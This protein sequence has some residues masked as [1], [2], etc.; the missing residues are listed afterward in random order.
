MPSFINSAY[1]QI[2]SLWIRTILFITH[3]IFQRL[4]PDPYTKAGNVRVDTKPAHASRITMTEIISPDQCDLKG[5]AYAGTI[6]SWIDIAAGIA[7]KRHA[8][9]PSV[10]RSVDDVAFLHP[11]KV[12]D[13]VSIQAS[14]NKSWKTSMEVGVKVEAESP[15]TNERFFVAHAYLTFVALSPRPTAKTHVGRVLSEYQPIRVPELIPTSSMEINRFEMAEKRRQARF[16][17]KKVDYQEIRNRMRE[18]SQ[19]LRTMADEIAP[20]KEHPSYSVVEHASPDMQNTQEEGSEEEDTIVVHKLERRFSQDPRMVQQ[21]K[22]KLM[23]ATFAE[24]VELVMPQHANTLSITFGGQI[25]AWMELCARVSANRLAKAYLLT[26]SIDSLNFIASSGVGDVVTI[27]SVVSRSFNSSMEV[28][29]SVEAENLS[30]GETKFTNDGFFTITAVDQENVPVV[31]PRIIPQT[32]A[33]V[34]LYEGG[35]DRRLKR[36]HQR[37]ELITLVKNSSKASTKS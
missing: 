6:L 32:K 21:I 13:I 22:E 4:L 15:I 1:E 26:A 23:D 25:M 11:V 37:Q 29:V 34:A 12:G 31:I 16:G 2:R 10:T 28:Y 20:I 5:F 8:V 7:A 30:T 35:H 17:Q 19:G 14:V 18:W 9:S 3:P 33:E 27:R 24:V 36:L